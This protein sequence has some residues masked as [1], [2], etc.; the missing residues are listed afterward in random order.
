MC[1]CTYAHTCA[2]PQMYF[3][4]VHSGCHCYVSGAFGF[5]S[6]MP[7]QVSVIL[8]VLGKLRQLAIRKPFLPMAVV[9]GMCFSHMRAVWPSDDKQ[10]VLIR[11]GREKDVNIIGLP[12]AF[13]FPCLIDFSLFFIMI[14]SHFRLF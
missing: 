12:F 10:L 2:H 8:Y 13:I 9:H 6:N 11:Q 5:F 14:L 7:M 3:W 4:H 1:A